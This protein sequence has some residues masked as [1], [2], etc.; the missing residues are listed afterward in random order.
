MVDYETIKLASTEA[1]H[2]VLKNAQTSPNYPKNQKAI[3]LIKQELENRK[4]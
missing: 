3:I 1:L 4:Q 2:Q